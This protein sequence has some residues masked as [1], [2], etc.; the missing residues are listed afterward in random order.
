MAPTAG[1]IVL[2]RPS[3]EP[4]TV[5]SSQAAVQNQGDGWRYTLRYL[6]RSID[7]AVA[8]ATD[9]AIALADHSS[10]LL[11]V[12]ALAARTAELHRALAVPTGDPSF[13][14][15]PFTAQRLAEWTQTI[16]S[17]L[18]ATL[19]ALRSRP[20]ALPPDARDAAAA[21]WTRRS[22]C[23]PQSRSA[24]PAGRRLSRFACTAT[25]T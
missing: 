25:S 9:G 20:G 22:A 15:E 24:P 10:Y 18:D 11:L 13:D 6:E 8:R 14:P 23:M 17:E 19:S 12:R 1:A 16:R 7:D 3:A 5:A 4:T 2:E 21:H